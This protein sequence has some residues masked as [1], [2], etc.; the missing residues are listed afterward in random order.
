MWTD[1]PIKQIR[2]QNNH[3]NHNKS[4]VINIL[5]RSNNTSTPKKLTSMAKRRLDVVKRLF[6]KFD[7][8]NS[9]YLTEEEIPFMLEQTYK[10]VGQT[11]KPTKED[12]KS[13]MRMVD[14][15]SDGKVTLD[16]FEEIVLLSL[17]KA[18]IEIYQKY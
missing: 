9:G 14:K 2:I 13:Y 7:K 12:V 4:I 1:Q 5:P 6:K 17:Q 15:N 3:N 8:D 10:E 11:Y 16:E 18:G